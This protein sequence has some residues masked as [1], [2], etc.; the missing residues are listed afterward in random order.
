VLL[1]VLF[2]LP[3]AGLAQQKAR[4]S[5]LSEALGA[6][7][8]LAGGSGPRSVNWIDGGKRYSYTMRSDSG[9][10]I[11][12]FDP[13]TGQDTLLFTA[14]G[15]AF[16][17]TTEPFAYQ[18]FQWA[19]DSK[20]LVFQTRFQ[21]IYRRSGISDY[22]VYALGDHSLKLAARGAR[23][24]E[25]SPGGGLLGYERGGDM[26]VHDRRHRDRIQRPFRLGLRGGIRHCAGL[27]LVPG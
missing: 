20:H 22:Y 5:D 10:E 18:S 24:A 15:R 9:E 21:Q 16:P 3:S 27:G 13:A 8:A 14:R 1:A 25:L 12:A 26:F 6:S 11:R 2:V 4:F 19:H 23:T 17:D 7:S